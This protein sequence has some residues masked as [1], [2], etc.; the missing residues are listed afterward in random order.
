MLG[1]TVSH[2]FT[3]YNTGD[4]DLLLTG[5]PKVTFLG[6]NAAD[7][8]VSLEP[9]SPVAPGGS[10]TFTVVF[11]P[12]AGGLR[13]T[14]LSIANNDSDENPYTFAIQGTGT[15]A[16]EMDVRGNGVS[17]PDEDGDPSAGG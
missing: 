9:T 2:S 6:G 15:L 5:T 7:F 16:P 14:T 11:N 4:G 8:S 3:I 10:T 17:I 12:S 13:T 1:G